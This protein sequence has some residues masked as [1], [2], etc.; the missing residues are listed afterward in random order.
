M[1]G[2]RGCVNVKVNLNRPYIEFLGLVYKSSMIQVLPSDPFG[3]LIRDLFRG[4]W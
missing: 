4:C 3:Y 1:G 2:F